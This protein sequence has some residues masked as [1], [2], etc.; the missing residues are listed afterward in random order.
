[1]HT[2]TGM[3]YSIGDIGFAGWGKGG[4]LFFLGLVFTRCKYRGFKMFGLLYGVNDNSLNLNPEL[5]LEEYVH[6]QIPP[7]N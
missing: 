6:A 7:D 4:S 5:I 3:A 1:M 2:P